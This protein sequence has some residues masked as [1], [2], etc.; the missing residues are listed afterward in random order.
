MCLCGKTDEFGFYEDREGTFWIFQESG[1]GL[2]ILDRRT[3]RLVRYSFASKDS[4][5]LTQSGVSS[6]LED[7]NGTLWVGTLSDGIL[8]FDRA[9]QRFTRYRNDPSNLEPNHCRP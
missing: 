5:G 4:P 7:R 8:K 1:N 2:A 9:R 6:M 3:H